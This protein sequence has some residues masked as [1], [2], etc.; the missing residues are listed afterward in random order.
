MF[1]YLFS[2]LPRALLI[3]QFFLFFNFFFFLFYLCVCVCLSFSPS[4]TIFHPFILFIYSFFYIHSVID[5]K[6][7]FHITSQFIYKQKKPNNNINYHTLY[8][9]KNGQYV[10]CTRITKKTFVLAEIFVLFFFLFVMNYE[11]FSIKSEIQTL[12]MKKK[13][14]NF[15]KFSYIFICSNIHA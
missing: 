14:Q 12:L 8:T 10:Q 4:R 9:I 11:S 15:E 13:N 5:F 7:F 2:V 1:T 3:L 6:Y